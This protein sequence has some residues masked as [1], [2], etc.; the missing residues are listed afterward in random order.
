MAVGGDISVALWNLRSNQLVKILGRH[1]TR[2][3]SVSFSIN[4][5][6]IAS[7]SDDGVI[8]LHN[9]EKYKSYHLPV[10]EKFNME[11]PIC[12][13]KFSPLQERMLAHCG[14]SGSVLIW[15]TA[16]LDILKI[17]NSHSTTC[18]DIIFNPRDKNSLCSGGLDKKMVIYDLNSKRYLISI[19]C[20]YLFTLN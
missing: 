3:N 10:S 12:R 16:R 15:D 2:V 9:I 19:S 5:T 4:K 11:D 17:Y 1:K 18:N 14:D 13:I 8:M 7:A 20:Y 6:H